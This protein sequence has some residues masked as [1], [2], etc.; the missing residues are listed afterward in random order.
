MTWEDTRDRSTIL[1]FGVI[2]YGKRPE[3]TTQSFLP[4]DAF[5]IFLNQGGIKVKKCTSKHLNQ[6][7]FS[8]TP[9]FNNNCGSQRP[10]F[11][12]RKNKI[13]HVKLRIK[14]VIHDFLH[15]LVTNR[16]VETRMLFELFV[17]HVLKKTLLAPRIPIPVE[18]SYLKQRRQKLLTYCIIYCTLQV[19]SSVNLNAWDGFRRE[20]ADCSLVGSFRDATTNLKRL[21]VIPLT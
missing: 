3:K 16:R 8:F 9:Y 6:V 18:P 4:R 7:N 15:F 10:K 11:R 13:V 2:V 1:S 5:A 12:P 20:N 21:F 17:L 19:T 14:I